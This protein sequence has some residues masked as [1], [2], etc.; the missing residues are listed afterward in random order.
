MPQLSP[1]RATGPA[2]R[3]RLLLVALPLASGAGLAVHILAGI[4]LRLA[5]AALVLAGLGIWLLL[6]PRMPAQRRAELGR[7]AWIG[8]V[9]GLLAT[10]AYDLARYGTVAV[11]EFSF[12]PFHVFSVF[13]HLFLG[14]AASAPAAFAAGAA[15]HLVNGTSFGIAYLLVRRR[16]GPLTGMAWGVAL[17]LAMATLYPSWLR[18]QQFGEFLQVSAIGHLVYG[19][20]LGLLAG[21][22]LAARIRPADG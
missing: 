9:A 3:W 16:P 20:T 2:G 21:R 14:P 7:R 18:I 10:F 5:V 12:Q 4:D 11:L 6:L 1:A 19:A 13:G 8:A 15:Y 17:E 22:M